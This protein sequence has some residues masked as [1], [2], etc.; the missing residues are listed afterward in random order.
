MKTKLKT[1]NSAY[2]QFCW[3]FAAG[4]TIALLVCG[5]TNSS[6]AKKTL[7]AQGYKHITITGYRPFRCSD[8]DSFQTG[9]QAE[10]PNGGWVSG[11]VCEGVLK[12]KTVRLD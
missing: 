2:W 10:S 11:T 6:G 9:F 3:K 4:L 5:C 12:G 7:E 8:D 1:M